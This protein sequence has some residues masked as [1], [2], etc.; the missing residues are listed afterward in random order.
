[1]A[2]AAEQRVNILLVDDRVENLV[3]LES[4]LDAPDYRLVRALNGQDAL[5]A[6]LADDFAAIVL[7]VQ[8]PG[9]SGIELAQLIRQRRKSQHVPILFLT[10]HGDQSAIDGYQAGAVDFLT[11]PVQAGVLRSK[12]AVFAELYRK[13]AALQAEVEERRIAE[14]NV[15]RLNAE[16]FSRVEEL[17]AAYGELEAFSYTVSH[18]LRAPL[19]QVSG[20]VALLSRSLAERQNETDTEYISLINGAVNRMGQLINDLLSFSRVSRAEMRRTTVDLRPL[21]DQVRETLAPALAGRAVSWKIAPLPCVEGDPAMLRQVFASLLDNA[22]KFTR[23]R[24]CAEIEVGASCENDEYVVWVRDNGVGFDNE[25]ADK[26]FGVFQRLHTTAEFEG[27][28]IGLA[29]VRRI[30]VRHNGRS[31]AE[32]APGKGTVVYFSLPATVKD[33]QPH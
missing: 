22:V 8:M 12:V 23:P 26:L 19:R 1:M 24:A 3:A 30:M 11:K 20:F 25:R 32:S 31:W 10:A 28:G 5:L 16:L 14:Q 4:I 9:M 33:E 13:S 6:V 27:T 7:D 29:S 15:K 18:D 17:A 2:A 21:V